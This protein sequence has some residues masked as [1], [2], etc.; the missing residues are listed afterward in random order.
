MKKILS[1]LK[2]WQKL[3]L[4]ILPTFIPTLFFIYII[5]LEKSQDLRIAESEKDGVIYLHQ[6]SMIVREMEYL[7][8]SIRL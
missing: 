2:I 3:I 7:N 5:Y 1:H 6:S 4:A 8:R